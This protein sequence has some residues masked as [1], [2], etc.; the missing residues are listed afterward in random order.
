M[1]SSQ[2]NLCVQYY[3]EKENGRAP[4][5]QEVR[6]LNALAG[7][8]TPSGALTLSELYTN[9]AFVAVTY[10]DMMNKRRELH[11]QETAPLSLSEALGIASA[12]LNR[13]GRPSA[14]SGGTDRVATLLNAQSRTKNDVGIES[15]PT[16]LRLSEK[17]ATPTVDEG[18]LFVLIHRGNTPMW[19]YR[20]TIDG[21]LSE[22]VSAALIKQVATVSANGLL[23]LLLSASTAICYRLSALSLDGYPVSP[24]VLIGH[25]E[26]YR[27]ALISKANVKALTDL[28]IDRGLRPMIFAAAIRGTRSHFIK[29]SDTDFSFET[30]FLQRLPQGEACVA[31]LATEKDASPDPIAHTPVNAGACAY[32]RHHLPAQRLTCEGFTVSAAHCK[33]ER[34]FFRSSMQT[35]LTAILSLAAGGCD[36][37][38]IRLALSL[39]LPAEQDGESALGNA[40]SAILGLYRV[41]CELGIPASTRRLSV[42]TSLSAPSLEVFAH[43][44]STSLPSSFAAAGN[45]IYCVA[46][47]FTGDN[48]PDFK[49]LRHLLSTLSELNARGAI[50]SARVLCGESLTDAVLALSKNGLSCHFTDRASVGR[51]AL[52]LAILLESSE[53]LPFVKIGTVAEEEASAEEAEAVLPCLANALNKGEQYEAV[54]FAQQ[55]DAHAET[56]AAVLSDLNVQCTVLTPSASESDLVRA[57][58]TAQLLILCKGATLPK[59]PSVRFALQTLTAAQGAVVSL[60]GGDLPGFCPVIRL[61][62]GFSSQNLAQMFS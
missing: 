58:L 6:F 47:L 9:D 22:S 59:T 39:S 24:E 17:K 57:S 46:P 62:N 10:A 19:K 45:Q 7:I 8:R 54:L 20:A 30:D 4:T 16:F 27:V 41:Q 55:N 48:L 43:A 52:P 32:L 13:V 44:P 31:K 12:Y 35:A 23:P 38:R 42:D 34:S 14:L 33:L 53:K 11:T 5:Q 60:N 56:L 61:E 50:K 29:S 28:L 51:D 49:A 3:K 37:T 2:K 18:D 40:I 21:L 15:A 25:F 1:N 36:H 26:E